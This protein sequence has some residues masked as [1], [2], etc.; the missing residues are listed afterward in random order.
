MFTPELKIGDKVMIKNWEEMKNEFGV[1]SRGGI[2]VLNVFTREMEYLCGKIIEVEKILIPRSTLGRYDKYGYTVAIIDG[3]HIS[4]GMVKKVEDGISDSVKEMNIRYIFNKRETIC[5]V[6][7][8]VENKY[9]KGISK[10]HPEDKYDREEGMKIAFERA[11]GLNVDK[12]KN[13]EIAKKQI[14]DN[15]SNEELLALLQKRLEV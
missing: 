10:A 3:Y 4:S 15:I 12:T 1:N 14:L 9:R 2:N 5:L 8:D 6:R 13:V 11:L 7:D